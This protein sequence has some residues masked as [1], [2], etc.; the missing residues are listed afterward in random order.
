MH[1]AWFSRVVK[2]GDST[3]DMSRSKYEDTKTNQQNLQETKEHKQKTKMK[4]KPNTP[5]FENRKKAPHLGS[6]LSS[7]KR[8]KSRTE[9]LNVFP[10]FFSGSLCSCQSLWLRIFVVD[11]PPFWLACRNQPERTKTCQQTEESQTS[12]IANQKKRK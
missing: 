10:S 3:E 8:D 5:S 9:N 12:R 11:P 6:K 7:V 2:M 4:C 1:R